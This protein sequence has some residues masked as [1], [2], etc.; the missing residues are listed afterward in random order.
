MK[1]TVCIITPSH[2]SYRMG[3]LEY[4][5][6][7][8]VDHLVKNDK[9]K[10]VYL[11]KKL[12]REFTSTDYD[13]VRIS[14]GNRLQKYGF[15]TDSLSLSMH[16]R[17]ISPEII[18]QRGGSAYTGVAGFY[19]KQA[20]CRM[21]W[22][23]S[24]DSDLSDDQ[25]WAVHLPHKFIEKNMLRWGIKNADVIITQSEFQKKTAKGINPRAIFH[26]TRNFHPCPQGK[27]SDSRSNTIIWIANIKKVKQPELYIELSKELVK[28]NIQ[29]ECLMIGA[30]AVGA[31]EYQ[32]AIEAGIADSGRVKYLGPMPM[33]GVNELVGKSLLLINTSQWEGFPNTFIQAWM[34]RTPVVSLHCD[35]DNVIKNFQCGLVSGSF[36]KMV[37]DVAYLLKNDRERELMGEKAYR[38]AFENHSLKNLSQLEQ[39]IL[40]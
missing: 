27:G 19:A 29:V 7:L 14:N 26:I 31:D 38:Y 32:M 9:I 24:S 15:F 39:I 30:P 20:G 2:W 23:I 16:L 3:G 4:Q 21:I 35:P 28:R 8:L 18:Y 11:A 10:V 22:H 13:L 6:K 5:V 33:D 25:K 34:R 36:A 37:D 17:K 40:G 12:S 1:K